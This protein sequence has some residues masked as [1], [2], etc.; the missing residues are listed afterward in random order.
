MNEEYSK[1]C[2]D[3]QCR[4]QRP[5]CPPPCPPPVCDPCYSNNNNGIWSWILILVILYCLFCSG[6][7]NRGGLLGGLF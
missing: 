5:E 3:C 7:D 1:Q 6:N 2:A 4:P